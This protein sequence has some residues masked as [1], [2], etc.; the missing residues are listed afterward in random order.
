MAFYVDAHCHLDL[1]S[2]PTQALDS[3]PNTIV[4]AVTELPSR[5]RLLSTRFRNEPRVRV[6]LGLHPLRATTAGAL[7][8]GLLIRQLD[9]TDYVGEV[10]LD[11]S[12]QG[13]ATRHAQ[14]R[15][16]ERLL[17]EPTLRRKVVSVHSRGAERA[18]IERLQDAGVTAILHWYT[19]PRGLVDDALSAGM[20]FSV[21]PA[22]LRGEKGRALLAA[23]PMDRVLTETDA[24]F[25][26]VNGANTVPSDIA[27]VVAS[28]AKQWAMT[29][30]AA[31]E[32]IHKNFVAL[33]ATTVGSVSQVVSSL[34][35]SERHDGAT[36]RP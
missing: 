30:D 36:E 18:A 22:M 20:Y 35:L 11:F 10:G 24:P 4:V 32:L 31:R 15:V 9:R 5:Y 29:G 1:L 27:A 6:A 21:N 7:E 16:F 17:A 25:A 13:R 34:P 19:G 3:A 33:H 8:E 26:R 2:R 28:L 14:L 12:A 23:L